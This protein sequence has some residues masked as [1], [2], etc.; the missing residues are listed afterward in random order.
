[1]KDRVH[2][3]VIPPNYSRE[4]MSVADELNGTCRSLDEVLE[5]RR[6]DMLLYVQAFLDELDQHAWKCETCDWWCEPSEMCDDD[7]G[8]CTDCCGHDH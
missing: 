6:L 5:D 2:D 8:Y 3:G 1:V 4:A 7:P